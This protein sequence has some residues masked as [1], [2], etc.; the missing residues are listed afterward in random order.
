MSISREA[1]IRQEGLRYYGFG[2]EAMKRTRVCT[3]CGTPTVS[4]RARCQVCGALLPRESLYECYRRLHACCPRCGAVLA[5]ETAY[6]PQCGKKLKR[7]SG[8]D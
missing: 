2:P 8:A 7:G 1:S 5:G 6:C 4:Q 3:C